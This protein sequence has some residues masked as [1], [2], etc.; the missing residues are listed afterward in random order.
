MWYGALSKPMVYV[1]NWMAKR[2]WI[3]DIK[4]EM[5]FRK[6]YLN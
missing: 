5:Q 2:V 3:R 6:C 4:F 1:N